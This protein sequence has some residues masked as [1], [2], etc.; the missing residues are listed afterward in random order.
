[1]TVFL[2]GGASLI[3]GVLTSITGQSSVYINFV[4]SAECN[5]CGDCKHGRVLWV[6]DSTAEQA[7]EAPTNFS[8]NGATV[9]WTSDMASSYDA[10]YIKRAGE[11]EF[12]PVYNVWGAGIAILNLGLLQGD[13]VIR[14]V[15]FANSYRSALVGNVLTTFTDSPYAE[16][17]ITVTSLK[18]A[19]AQPMG[20]I[21][22]P[23]FGGW[24]NSFSFNLPAGLE[25]EDV[26]IC[27]RFEG[28]EDFVS[29]GV[30]SWGNGGNA[31]MHLDEPIEGVHTVRIAFEAG[32]QMLENGVLITFAPHETIYLEIH[33]TVDA[34][35]RITITIL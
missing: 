21:H 12:E 28:E 7:L 5:N 2:A 13:N 22:N 34:D 26:R 10:V 9:N 17:T 16:Y 18:D 31:G 29:V 27:I 25:R 4:L 32:G 14:V 24:S 3:N 6:Y 11:T 35:E 20:K 19:P 33:A 30:N 1:M 15:S 23:G 8:I